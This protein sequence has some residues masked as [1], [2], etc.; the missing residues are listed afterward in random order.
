MLK[1]ILISYLLEMTS[2][3]RDSCMYGDGDQ[4]TQNV[5]TRSQ[6]RRKLRQ[7]RKLQ[8]NSQNREKQLET[9]K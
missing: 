5:C 7:K 9:E 1:I 6:C 4:I 3:R 2:K 8:Q